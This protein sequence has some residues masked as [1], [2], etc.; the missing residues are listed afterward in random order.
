MNRRN[1]VLAVVLAIQLVLA[2]VLFFP[3]SSGESS[4]QGSA[5]LGGFKPGSV[6]ELTVHD[7]DGNEVRLTRAGEADWVVP[8]FGDYPVDASKV[9]TLLLK[10][11]GLRANRLIARNES[12]HARLKVAGDEYER[13]IELKRD[14]GQTDRLYL[15][16][17]AGGSDTHM[18]ANDSDRVYLVGGLGSWEVPATVGGWIDTLYFSVVT[19]NVT[20]IQ[21][22]NASGVFQFQKVDG[23]WTLTGLEADE[24]FNADSVTPLLNRLAALRMVEP[25][26][27]EAQ[28]DSGMDAPQAVITLTVQEQVTVEPDAASQ[29][30]VGLPPALG[31]PDT[32]PSPVPTPSVET[33]EKTYTLT[34]GATLEDGTYVLKSS[35]SEYYVRLAAATAETFTNLARDGLLVVPTPTPEPTESAPA[36]TAEPEATEETAITPVETPSAETAEPEATVTGAP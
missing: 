9:R 20:M 31:T 33:V 23:A 29:P 13:L 32:T 10:L 28:D 27:K 21:V 19:D 17:T 6:V 30:E 22:E 11:E 2:L 15:G 34:I 3:R 26:G 12:S 14:D 18:R 35:E 5:L 16:S 4:D 24:I 1:Q 7:A 36:E 8:A 25:I